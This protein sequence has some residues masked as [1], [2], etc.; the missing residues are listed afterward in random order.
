[1]ALES[2]TPDTLT[3]LKT[4]LIRRLLN[5][6]ETLQEPNDEIIQPNSQRTLVGY[7][8]QAINGL[9]NVIQNEGNVDRVRESLISK[10]FYRRE[11]GIDNT[12]VLGEDGGLYMLLNALP[13]LDILREAFDNRFIQNTVIRNNQNGEGTVITNRTNGIPYVKVGIGEGAFGRVRFAMCILP[14]KGHDVSPPILIGVKK[15]VR[16][17]GDNPP[18]KTDHIVNLQRELEQEYSNQSLDRLIHT[19]KVYDHLIVDKTHNDKRSKRYL[20]FE[21]IPQSN[22]RE[23]F[24]VAAN[25]VWTQQQSY[26][27]NFIEQ[28]NNLAQ[29]GIFLTDIKP[30]NTLFRPDDGQVTFIDIGS[31]IQSSN[32]KRY[33]LDA[34]VPFSPYFASQEF[35]SSWEKVM[36]RTQ[37]GIINLNQCMS[38]TLGKILHLILFEDNDNGQ[39]ADLSLKDRQTLRELIEDLTHDKPSQRPSVSEARDILAD[40]NPLDEGDIRIQIVN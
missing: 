29:K 28:M 39:H 16:Y 20:L 4:D 36:N 24:R 9:L 11:F 37:P 27:L 25:C 17:A 12:V 6:R 35:Q 23:H 26:F 2:L 33:T 7:L 32:P 21:L 1:M 3:A 31:V 38:Y 40:I 30:Q 22:A 5:R 10:R 8:R 19:P 15:S 18:Q 13:N 14:P 34:L